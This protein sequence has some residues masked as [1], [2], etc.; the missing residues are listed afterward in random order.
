MRIINVLKTERG[1][2]EESYS[3]VINDET[4][5]FDIIK[6]AEDKFIE[7]V[8]QEDDELTEKDLYDCL[9]SC[10]YSNYDGVSIDIYFSD[11]VIEQ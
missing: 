3:F 7:L 9:D 4:K 10:N 11:Q 2:I 1:I 6:A 8:S 5:S